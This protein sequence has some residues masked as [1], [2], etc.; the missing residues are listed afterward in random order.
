MST[1]SISDR[2]STFYSVDPESDCWLWSGALSAQGRYPTFTLGGETVYAHR[3]IFAQAYGPIPAEHD[4]HHTCRQ[5]RCVNPTHLRAITH[6]EHM[7]LHRDE[8]Q[9]ERTRLIPIAAALLQS[10]RSYE[11]V[12]TVTGLPKSLMSPILSR[13]RIPRPTLAAA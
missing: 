2:F 8:R 12:R 7:A 6:P 10:G 9:A 1:A 13:L 3:F 4:I 11:Q 5:R